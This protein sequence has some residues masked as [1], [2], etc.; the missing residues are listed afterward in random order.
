MWGRTDK[1]K[2]TPVSQVHQGESEDARGLSER[3]IEILR[4]TAANLL[5]SEIAAALGLAEST[6]KWY[7]KRIF[8]KRGVHRRFLAVRVARMRGLIA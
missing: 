2:T 8:E 7:W 1:K 5:T 6:I 3:E 4:L